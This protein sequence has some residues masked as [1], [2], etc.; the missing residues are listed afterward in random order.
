MNRSVVIMISTAVCSTAF[1][2][3]NTVMSKII[4]HGLRFDE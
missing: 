1:F 3:C 2:A 4:Y